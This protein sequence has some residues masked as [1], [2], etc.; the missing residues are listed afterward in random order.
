VKAGKVGPKKATPVKR[1]ETQQK[2]SV[3]DTVKKNV[4]ESQ[5]SLNIAVASR[6]KFFNNIQP[7][8]VGV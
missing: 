4:T 7:I 2:D 8:S 5:S 6:G 3:V 1:C